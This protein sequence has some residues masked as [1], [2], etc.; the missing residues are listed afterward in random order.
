MALNSTS[1]RNGLSRN[2]TA[3][4]FMAWTVMGTSLWPVI[5][6]I[7]MS[8]R[9]A[10]SRFCRSRPLMSG[11]EMSSTRQLG[12]AARGW[13]RNSWAEENVSGCQPSEQI[14]NSSDSRTEMSSSTTKTIGIERGDLLRG[15]VSIAISCFIA[16]GMR[17]FA[18][19]LIS[20]SLYSGPYGHDAR[21]V[22][23]FSHAQ[24]PK[25]SNHGPHKW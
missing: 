16:V 21:I 24:N 17:E 14:N 12:T 22:E 15:T 3:P 19:E 23:Q 7:G 20:H 11:R 5:K 9:S 10:V 6:M 25:W 4:A 13:V 8:A 1:S 18:T 2:S